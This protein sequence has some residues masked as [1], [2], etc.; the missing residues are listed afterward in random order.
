MI[1]AHYFTILEQN[2][3]EISIIFCQMSQNLVSDEVWNVLYIEI[4]KSNRVLYSLSMKCACEIDC[5]L[6]LSLC[7][8]LSVSVSVSS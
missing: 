4:V 7:V 3:T 5:V 2:V 1:L 8:C 6:R